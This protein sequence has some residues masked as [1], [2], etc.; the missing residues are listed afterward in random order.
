MSFNPLAPGLTFTGPGGGLA[1][2][3]PA[4]NG[5]TLTVTQNPVAYAADV[6]VGG[7]KGALVVLPHNDTATGRSQSVPI[8]PAAAGTAVPPVSDTAAQPVG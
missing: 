1:L 3:L 2:L 8:G 4:A 5:T 7:R 6:A